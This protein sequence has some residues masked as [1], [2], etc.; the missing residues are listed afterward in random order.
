MLPPDVPYE[1]AEDIKPLNK[2]TSIAKTV[3]YGVD[4]PKAT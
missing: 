3:G 2:D 1:T 4:P